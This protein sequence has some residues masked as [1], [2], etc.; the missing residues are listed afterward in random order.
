MVHA[1]LFP[2]GQGQCADNLYKWQT[3]SSDKCSC[4]QPQTMNHTV[5]SCP[6][7]KLDDDGL[8]Q[9]HFADDNMVIWLSDVA[10]KVRAM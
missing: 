2:D 9:L 7:S 5:D 4:G 6:L 1:E 10:M 8:V 3:A